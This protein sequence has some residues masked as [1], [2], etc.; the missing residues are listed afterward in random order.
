MNENVVFPE[1]DKLD[2]AP[3]D[4][5]SEGSEKPMSTDDI[6]EFNDIF[7]NV[8]VPGSNDN[9]ILDDDDEANRTLINCLELAENADE[10]DKLSPIIEEEESLSISK[11]PLI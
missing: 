11:N 10:H 2:F 6:K 4:I 9:I 7:G 5:T 1:D 8:D 3:E